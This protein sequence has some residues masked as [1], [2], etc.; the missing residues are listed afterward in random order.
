M[1]AADITFLSLAIGLLLML[2]PVFYLWKLKTDLVIATLIGT[3]RMCVQLFLIG[4]YLR[5]LFAWNSP[6]INFLWVVIMAVVASHTAVVRTKLRQGVLFLPVFIGFMTT[7]VLVGFFFLGIVLQLPNVFSAQYFVP[8][9]GVLMGNMLS[10]NVVALST[11]YADLKREQQMYYY[12]LGNG[13]TRFEAT[14]PFLRS[15]VIKA[16]SPCIAN[17]AVMGV[18]A[19]PGTMVGQILGGSMP[20]V[21]IKYQMMIVVITMA[22][23]ML[24]LMITVSLSVRKSFDGYGRLKPVFRDEKHK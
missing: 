11:Y 6:W 5:Y 10:V 21:A 15:A 17:M 16:F 20:G 18:V 14:V 3:V 9:I 19:L 12:L 4:I 23:S 24:S 7:A 13:A 8:I 2:V 22:A 1:N